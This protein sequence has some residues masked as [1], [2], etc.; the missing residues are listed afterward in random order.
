MLLKERETLA[1]SQLPA[2]IT[3]VGLQQFTA[4]TVASSR[5]GAGTFGGGSIQLYCV[6]STPYDES[7]FYISCDYCKGWF[8]GECV[9]VPEEQAGG[10]GGECVHCRGQVAQGPQCPYL[11]TSRPGALRRG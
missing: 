1:Q 7:R 10:N 11:L 8:H 5:I 4:N 9:G 6:C 3:K 2:L